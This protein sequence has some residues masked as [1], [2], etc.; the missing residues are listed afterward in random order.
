MAPEGPFADR[1]IRYTFSGGLPGGEIWT[2]GLRTTPAIVTLADL[3]GYTNEVGD[4]FKTFFTDTASIYSV[5]PSTVTYTKCT[6]Y[7]IELDGHASLVAERTETGAAGAAPGQTA[8]NQTAL[9]VSLKTDTAGRSGRGRIYLPFLAPVFDG[10]Q[11]KLDHTVITPIGVKFT[12]FL[13]AVDGLSVGAGD[14]YPIAIQSRASG[15]G[16]VPARAASY[17]Q[18][19][20][21]AIGDVADTQRRRRNKVVETYIN[22]TVG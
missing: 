3:E 8:P 12:V 5:N 21:L 6:G 20:H 4:L 11:D 16:V 7:Q 15:A 19:T 9:V 1:H 14:Q 18:V 13:N 17:A 22:F 2:C 10:V